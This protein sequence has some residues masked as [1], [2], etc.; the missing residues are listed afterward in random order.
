MYLAVFCVI[1][2]S[3][4]PRDEMNGLVTLDVFETHSPLWYFCCFQ[5]NWEESVW[6]FVLPLLPWVLR[7]IYKRHTCSVSNYS[8]RSKSP[9]NLMA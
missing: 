7:E 9:A 2:F 3:E 1:A 4:I 8:C 5:L 6:T